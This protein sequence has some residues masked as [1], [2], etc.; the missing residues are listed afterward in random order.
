MGREGGM[1][2]EVRW[3]DADLIAVWQMQKLGVLRILVCRLGR[4]LPVPEMQAYSL[5]PLMLLL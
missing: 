1:E 4:M 2:G 3:Q 5:F